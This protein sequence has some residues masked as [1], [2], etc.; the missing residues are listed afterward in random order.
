MHS[1]TVLAALALGAYPWLAAA[2]EPPPLEDFAREPQIFD[3]ALSPDG[4]Y[5]EWVTAVHDERAVIVLDRSV[6]GSKPR[7]VMR[8]DPQGRFD[9]SWCR[10][11]SDTRLVCGITGAE[12]IP[13]G[14]VYVVTRL[15]AVDAD[16]KNPRELVSDEDAVGFQSQ[17]Q[18][19]VVDWRPGKSDTVLITEQENAL[20]ARARAMVAAG[21]GSIGQ[22]T[23]PYPSVFELNTATGDMQVRYSPRAPLRSFVSDRHGNVRLGWGVAQNSDEMEYDVHDAGGWHTLM[24]VNALDRT[25]L[26]PV[27]ICPDNPDCAYAFGSYQGRRALWRMDLTGKVAPQVEFAHPA[28][29]VEAAWFSYDGRL[30]GARYDTDRPFLYYI[31]P[32]RESIVRAVQKVMPGAFILVRDVTQD[33][34]LY[35]L[36]AM[37]D[38]DDGTF[39]LFDARTGSLMKLG[40]A[41]PE[42]EHVAL[43]RM[44]SISYT[45]RDGTT[46]PGYLTVPPG[47]RPEHL[48]L[49]VMPHGG[50]AARDYWAFD[51]LR[52]FLVSRGYAVLQ[53]EFRGSSGY[54]DDWLNVARQDWGGLTY[55]D[56]EDGARWAVKDGIADPQ[57][58]C[59]VGWSFGGYAALVGAVRDGDLFRCAV[60]IAGVSDLSLLERQYGGRLVR[61]QVGT[62]PEKLKAESPV[63][64]VDSMNIPL[65]MIHGDRDAQSQIAQSRAMDAA[66]TEAHKAHQYIEIPGATHQMSRESDRMIL[67]SSIEKFLKE[68]LGPGVAPRD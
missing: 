63:R 62:D 24:T 44:Q 28:V 21:G 20:D 25:V 31:D 7:A 54:G 32:K 58:M 19:D 45:A 36:R 1:R 66:L 60:S 15:A 64:H 52:L 16:G 40:T 29:D 30:V 33:E 11:V 59:I 9:L 13:D 65:L 37:S 27:A 10:F 35:L 4:R 57:R 34:S 3:A 49:V 53:M 68:H 50:P 39:L 42:L 56:I 5:L 46:I 51:F 55:S 47:W 12:K 8:S 2:A 14:R 26:E 6:P 17:F 22:T 48:P 43:G 18:D 38:I 61:E 23:A 41:Y 67:L